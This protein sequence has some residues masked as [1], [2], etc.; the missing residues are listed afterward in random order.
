MKTQFLDC[1]ILHAAKPFV[2]WAGGKSQLLAEVQKTLPSRFSTLKDVVYVEPFV[3]GGAVLFWILQHYPNICR[4]VVNDINPDLINVYQHLKTDPQTLIASLRTMQNDYWSLDELERKTYFLMQRALF[5]HRQG[6]G[7]EQAA[8]FIFLNRTCFNGLYRVNGRGEFNVPHG[9]YARPKICDEENLLAVSVLLQK[10]EI[11]CGDFSQTLPYASV[12]TLFYLDPPYKPINATSSF[13]AYAKYGFDDDEQL[14][15]AR[16]AHDI[17]QQGAMLIA[18]NS[19]PQTVDTHN[20]FFHKA[21]DGFQ[22]RKVY[23]KRMINARAD[24]RGK[25][26]ELMITNI[27]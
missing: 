25:L 2:K 24:R 8:R 11:L 3:G 12:N 14:R 20:D 1:H 19:D 26:S 7:D 10:V 5:N 15:V 21:Y 18:S 6:K 23:A 16:F 27:L 4:A 17:A 13:T 22:I 9:R